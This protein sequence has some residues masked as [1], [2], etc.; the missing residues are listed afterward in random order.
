M[1]LISD[2][3]YVAHLKNREAVTKHKDSENAVSPAYQAGM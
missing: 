3:F 1:L 2:E